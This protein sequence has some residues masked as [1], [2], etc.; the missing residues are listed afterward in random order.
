MEPER[1]DRDE[2]PGKP[3]QEPRQG[4]GGEKGQA[5]PLH[6]NRVGVAPGGE[7]RGVAEARLPGMAGQHHEAHARDGPDEDVGGLPDQEIVENEGQGEREDD[8]PRVAER[9][10]RVRKEPDVVVVAGLEVHPHRFGPPQ[11]FLLRTWDT[12]PWGR[13]IST[14]SIS[15]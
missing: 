13:R 4:E 6:Q 3:G 9:P 7:E 11:T 2:N 5:E 15:A 1:G 10:A 8:E 12:I 14:M